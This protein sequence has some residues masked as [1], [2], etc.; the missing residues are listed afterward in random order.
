LKRKLW[1]INF[2]LLGLLGWSGWEL[3]Q[4]H[5]EAR[6][7]ELRMFGRP[8]QSAAKPLA[9]PATVPQPV[10]ATN[11]LEVAEKLLFS[12]DR[13]STVVIEIAPPQ[14]MPDLPRAHGLMAFG[15]DPTIVLS[16]KA[17]GRQRGYRAGETIGPFKL[18]ALKDGNVIFEWEGQQIERRV[19]DILVRSAPAIEPEPAP[20]ASA[21][22]PAA[23]ATTVLSSETAKA[24]PGVELGKQERACNPG[25]ASPPGAFVDGMRKVVSQTPFGDSCRWVPVK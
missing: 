3:R 17:G 9:T 21:P 13:N 4:R 20:A 19:E 8:M 15:G 23:S 6:Q 11:Y 16:E 14:P 10:T 18:L 7:R 24:A 22:P 12:R 2:V 5:F 25:D 1:L